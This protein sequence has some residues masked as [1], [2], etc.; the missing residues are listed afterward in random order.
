M[1]EEDKIKI[2][3]RYMKEESKDLKMIF[4][5]NNFAG[6]IEKE[7]N[8]KLLTEYKGIGIEDAILNEINL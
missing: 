5:K 3:E 7:K 8:I 4:V 6:F 2:F 1:T